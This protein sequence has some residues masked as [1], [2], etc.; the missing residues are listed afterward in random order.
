MDSDGTTD[1]VLSGDRETDI[2]S[3]FLN[4]IGMDKG[5]TRKLLKELERAENKF[6]KGDFVKTDSLVYI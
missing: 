3:Y 2:G 1:V 6:S 4:T 5:L